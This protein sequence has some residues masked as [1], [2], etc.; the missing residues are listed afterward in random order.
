MPALDTQNNKVQLFR[1]D[2]I[3]SLTR[4]G[5]KECQSKAWLQPKLVEMHL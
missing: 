1:V 4:D 3:L 2:R 5:I